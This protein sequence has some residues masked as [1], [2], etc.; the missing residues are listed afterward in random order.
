MAERAQAGRP[1]MARYLG[2][3]DPK[4]TCT[5]SR[6]G[7]KGHNKAG[8][9]R[10]QRQ[11]VARA[12]KAPWREDND[13]DSEDEAIDPTKWYYNQR[14]IERTAMHNSVATAVRNAT[15]SAPI[16]FKEAFGSMTEAEMERVRAASSIQ[17][18]YSLL[19]F[20]IAIFF[21]CFKICLECSLFNKT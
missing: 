18:V 13:L 16:T 1:K 2:A 12:M 20:E 15:T 4:S 10:R 8:C 6:C 11:E 14:A 5:C 19:G 3:L 17:Y 21:Y 9:E 7:Q